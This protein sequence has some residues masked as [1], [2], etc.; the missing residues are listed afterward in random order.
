MLNLTPNPIVLIAESGETTTIAPSGYVAGVHVTRTEC[1]Y[2]PVAKDDMSGTILKHHIPLIEEIPKQI[3]VH[4]KGE[5]WPLDHTIIDAAAF[6]MYG[7]QGIGREEMLLVTRDVAEAA[8]MPIF[9][10]SGCNCCRGGGCSTVSPKPHPLAERM[11]W[12]DERVWEDPC[13]GT[14]CIYAEII[15]YRSLRRVPRKDEA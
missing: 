5:V 9:P 1:D 11:V 4:L 14:D 15:G 2:F 7:D 3:V 13:D 8:A 6:N 10:V 12:P